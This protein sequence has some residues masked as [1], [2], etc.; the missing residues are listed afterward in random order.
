VSDKSSFCQLRRTMT[1][2]RRP[3]YNQ[4]LQPWLTIQKKISSYLEVRR[5][6]AIPESE[7]SGLWLSRRRH[8]PCDLAIPTEWGLDALYWRAPE[9]EVY[10]RLLQNFVPPTSR[11]LPLPLYIDMVCFPRYWVP[12]RWPKPQ[13][14][15]KLD[16]STYIPRGDLPD[17]YG[18]EAALDSGWNLCRGSVAD[19]TG[20]PGRWL[21]EILQEARDHVRAYAE[22]V[23]YHMVEYYRQ[24]PRARHNMYVAIPLLWKEVWFSENM[25]VPLPPILTYR[26]SRSFLI[27]FTMTTG[28]F[29]SVSWK[30]SGRY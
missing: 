5:L 14:P 4:P 27:K 20:D 3:V 8:T 19:G 2:L 6:E 16:F 11:E 30:M 12:Y 17:P 10:G 24:S 26:A 25:N 15:C 21:R 18:G 22:F 1:E 9:E 28:R 13:S 29:P 7:R 23:P